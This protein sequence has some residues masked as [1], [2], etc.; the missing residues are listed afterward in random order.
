M[1]SLSEA[2]ASHIKISVVVPVHNKEKYIGDAIDSVLAQTVKPYEIILVDDAS[3][4][5]S[6]KI[7]KDRLGQLGVYLRRSVPGAGGYAARNAGILAAKGDWIAFLDAD[8]VWDKRFIER[9]T[10][11]IGTRGD[12]LGCVF[13]GYSTF[14]GNVHRRDIFGQ[15]AINLGRET[16]EVS[17]E[18]FLRAWLTDRQCPIWTS[19]SAF[20]R[21]ILIQ[22]GLFPEGRCRRGGDKDLWIRAVAIAPA[23]Y[24]AAILAFYRQSDDAGQVT[25]TTATNSRHCLCETINLLILKERGAVRLLLKQVINAEIFLYVKKAFRSVPVGRAVYSDLRPLVSPVLSAAIL[26]MVVLSRVRKPN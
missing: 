23:A 2:I 9:I 12:G 4:D 20:R 26:T 7:A 19:A 15:R 13:T 18:E 22:A 24:D 6:M 1:N 25:K 3:S 16:G 8:D 14:A 5:R 11:R 10:N 21:D 17:F